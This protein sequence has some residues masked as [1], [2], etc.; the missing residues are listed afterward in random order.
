[1][2]TFSKL[3]GNYYLDRTKAE[4]VFK[5]K[6][7]LIVSSPLD[8]FCQSFANGLLAK[9]CLR[10]G[11]KEIEIEKIFVKKQLVENDSVMV[12][13]LSPIVVYSTL[14]KANGSKYTCYFQPGEPDYNCLI[15]N[16]LRKKYYALYGSEASKEKIEIKTRGRMKLNIVKYKNIIIKG[17]SGRLFLKGPESLLQMA[18]ESGLGSKNSQGFGCI[19]II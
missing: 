7:K 18:V 5:N 4:M 10:I 17:Y 3:I 1:M 2:Y 13:T 8:D 16:N 12:K 15:E 9:G 14:Y 6:I 11:A 19:E